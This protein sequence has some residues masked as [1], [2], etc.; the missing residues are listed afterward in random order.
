MSLPF[1]WTFRP[2]K[3]FPIGNAVLQVWP[4]RSA[5]TAIQ[6]V[7]AGAQLISIESDTALDDRRLSLFR[8]EPRITRR[9]A[10][11]AEGRCQT[12]GHAGIGR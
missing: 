4:M 10:R 9:C 12:L 6:R 3:T 7:S 5:T 1:A 2:A 8:M 11:D